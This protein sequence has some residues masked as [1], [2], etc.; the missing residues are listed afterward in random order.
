MTVTNNMRM[1]VNGYSS[2][3]I[4]TLSLKA[5]SMSKTQRDPGPPS[6][7]LKTSCLPG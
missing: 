1:P 5:F 6:A 7:Q 4:K 3:W 2:R